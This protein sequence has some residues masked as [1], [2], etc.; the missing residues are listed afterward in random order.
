VKSRTIATTLAT[1]GT[2]ALCLGV[3]GLPPA[4]AVAAPTVE[5]TSQT[6]VV[7]ASITG[8][9][10]FALSVKVTGASAPVT[11][12]TTL[13]NHL[14]TRS[15]LLQA[16]SSA[17]PSGQIDATDP[18]DASCLPPSSHG[19]VL[20]HIDV[21]TS[22]ATSPT[23]PGGCTGSARPPSFDLRC[24]IGSGACNGVYPVAIEIRI[25]GTPLPKLVTLMTF[26]ERP[27]ATPLRVS[28]LLRVNSAGTDAAELEATTRNLAKTTDVP[29]DLSVEPGLVTSLRRSPAGTTALASLAQQMADFRP[30]REL[31]PAPYVPVDPGALAA[32]GLSGQLTAQ[33]K[34][35]GELLEE[36]G[37]SPSNSS[38]WVASS[39]VTASTTP[40][41]AAAGLSHLIIPDSSLT[42]PTATSTTWGQPFTVSPGSSSITAIAADATLAAQARSGSVLGAMQL[43]GDLSLLHFERPSLTTPQGVVVEMTA[44][45]ATAPFL[46]A[47]LS[48]LEGN[49][50]LQANTVASLFAQVPAGGNG[51]PTTRKLADTGP[52]DAWPSSQ[53]AGLL[54]EQARQAAFASALPPKTP[55]LANLSDE[56]LSTERDT[57]SGTARS[58]ALAATAG[59]LDAQLAKVSISGAD[60]TLTSLRSSIPITLTSQ[61]GYPVTGVLTLSSAHLSFPRG[62]SATEDLDRPTLSL[63]FQ[64]QAVTTGDLPLY[65]SLTTPTG[66]LVI[67][68]QR[69]L[70][71]VTHTSI[72]AIVLTV[73]SAL[74]LLLWWFRTW[75]RAPRSKHRAAR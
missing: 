47:Y 61:T 41:L 58:K 75:W 3:L 1:L 15:G 17:G 48:G 68:H 74:V 59:S 30:T 70:I 35:G 28:T 4:S 25:G 62:S 69:I 8:Q 64:V 60:I 12:A 66:G 22:S 10:D 2:V 72:V 39:P 54:G 31:L 33:L 49:P 23:L 42:E 46:S 16:L 21:V 6:P 53:S 56:L 50:L 19:G 18:L 73:G 67:A 24:S 7:I 52:S 20:L 55:V 14:S 5:L 9:S 26:A 45:A 65:A 13:Y 71:H 37:L 63:R 43:L 36:A 44:S 51:A 11:I 34:R 32:S 29:L 40:A 38:T 57:L 27:A